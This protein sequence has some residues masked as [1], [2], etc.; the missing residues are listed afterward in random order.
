MFE[1]LDQLEIK[2][3]SLFHP[4]AIDESGKKFYRIE[5]NAIENF[6]PVFAIT[7]NEGSIK[8]RTSLTDV[9]KLYCSLIYQHCTASIT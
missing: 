3:S 7:F 8:T 2:L 1:M 6:Q 4:T 9:I 5:P